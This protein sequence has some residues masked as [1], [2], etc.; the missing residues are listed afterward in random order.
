MYNNIN[1]N[2]HKLII[3]IIILYST[4]FRNYLKLDRLILVWVKL[5][6]IILSYV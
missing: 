4:L 1:K 2:V 6:S 5:I 3:N